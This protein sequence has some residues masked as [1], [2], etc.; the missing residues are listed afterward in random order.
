LNRGLCEAKVVLDMRRIYVPVVLASLAFACGEKSDNSVPRAATPVLETAELSTVQAGGEGP[1][2]PREIPWI[3]DDWSSASRRAQAENKPVFADMWA[4]WCHTCLSM[5]ETVFKDPS[6]HPYL[7]RFVW[8]AADTDKEENAE[9]VSKVEMNMWPT[10]F[11]LDGAD[12]SVQASFAGGASVAQ[13]R[14]FLDDSEAIY[15]DSHGQNLGP[16]DPRRAL[17]D[18]ARALGEQRYAEAD[19]AYAHALAQAP[20]DWAR[21]PDVLVDQIR[22]RY[23]A[24]EWTRCVELAQSSLD[25]V[26]ASRAASVTD[27]S[28]YA[29]RCSKHVEAG[30][31]EALRDRLR[32]NLH[33]LADDQGAAL[34]IDD[35]SDLFANLRQLYLEDGRETEARAVAIRQRDLLSEAASSAPSPR[36]AMTYNWPRA[37]VHVYLGEPETLLP[38]LQA[39]AAALPKEYDPAYRLAW[40]LHEMKRE[41]EALVHANKAAALTYGPRKARVL[42]LVAEIQSAQG[43]RTAARSSLE[44]ALETLEALPESQRS[45]ASIEAARGRIKEHAQA[46]NEP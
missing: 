9:L 4:P 1:A 10:F 30:A 31:G 16:N 42:T 44:Q 11:V 17:R 36:V 25:A 12:G 24:Q 3:E 45:E 38:D 43:D 2:K 32:K 18:G 5:Q 21:R 13:I 29:G 8:L 6:L 35:R 26:N 15:L 28:L 27:F 34:S 33:A 19:A 41:D 20:A 7:D 46:S 14:A 23:K 22:S 40:L 39:S 37:E